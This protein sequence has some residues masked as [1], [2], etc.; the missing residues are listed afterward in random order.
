M[1]TIASDS[2]RV[3]NAIT[4]L[5]ESLG[6]HG[7]RFNDRLAIICRNGE[8]SIRTTA[9][10]PPEQVLIGLPAECLLPV[11][12]FQLSLSGN[13][14]RI[15]DH[16]PGVSPARREIMERVIEVLNLM[17]KV[18][19]HR[20]S[21]LSSLRRVRP[22]VFELLCS[23]RIPQAQQPPVRPSRNAAAIDDLL[24]TRTLVYRLDAASS[25][26]TLVIMPIIDFCNHHPFAPPY[27]PALDPTGRRMLTI[28]AFC[29]DPVTRECFVRYGLYDS[30]D[31]FLHYGFVD[32]QTPF[33]ISIPI[34]IDL[35]SL[36][37]LTVHA[38]PMHTSHAQIPGEIADLWFYLPAFSVDKASRSAE[39]SH[40]MIPQENAPDALR[41]IL[42]V[43]LSQIEP[44]LTERLRAANIETIEQ[45]ILSANVEFYRNLATYLRDITLP[46]HF[47]PLHRTAEAVVNLQLEK[48]QRYPY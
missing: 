4:R 25:L 43:I 40:L 17:D 5:L 23:G 20:F 12:D 15:S 39:V 6:K 28:R 2:T 22:E 24:D 3:A 7:A 1:V 48:L 34:E 41:R 32:R 44:A 21:T 36:G 16:N 33:I 37:T 11:D 45:R 46:D 31:C 19:R 30:Y 14:I 42:A 29:P 18:S 8:L 35:P 13:V 9:I 10:V 26:H 38:R 47:A 27:S